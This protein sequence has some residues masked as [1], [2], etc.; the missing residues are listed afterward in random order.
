M[1]GLKRAASVTDLVPVQKVIPETR[2]GRGAGLVMRDGSYRLLLR[3]GSVNFDMKS[4]VE[5]DAL[6]WAFG[7]LCNSLDDD[8]PIQICPHSK[9]LDISSYLNQFDAAIDDHRTSPEVKDL[10]NGHREHF[11][12]IVRT[13]NLLSRE[14]YVVIPWK[15]KTMHVE[16]A[17][18]DEFPLAGLIK[19][20]MENTEKRLTNHTPSD[21][22]IS[23]AMES[24][25]SRANSLQDRLEQIGVWSTRIDQDALRQLLWE[26]FH[27][28]RAERQAAPTGAF[29]GRL[30]GGFSSEAPP[31]LPSRISGSDLQPPR[32]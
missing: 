1:A 5:R 24:L 14:F 31:Q 13:R 32:F 23:S 6:T 30:T 28:A 16:A 27:P 3:A 26:L 20:F 19:K 11:Q 17:V 29:D 25:D 18:T 2:P 10:I 7:A 8:F 4:D 22:E 15:L 12:S 21:Q 9:R